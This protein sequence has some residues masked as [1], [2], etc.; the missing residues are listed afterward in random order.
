MCISMRCQSIHLPGYV[1]CCAYA[2]PPLRPLLL[3]PSTSSSL[4]FQGYY[5]YLAPAIED[6]QS[7]YFGKN[8]A[9]LQVCRDRN[10]WPRVVPGM[11]VEGCRI[12]GDFLKPLALGLV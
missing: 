6:W 11:K 4:T 8:Y 1:S 10:L 7:F 9:R 3:R 2:R 12:V 5:N